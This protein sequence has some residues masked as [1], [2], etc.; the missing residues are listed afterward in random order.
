[1][2]TPRNLPGLA[3][4]AAM[5]AAGTVLLGATDQQ[6]WVRFMTLMKTP[7]PRQ[8]KALMKRYVIERELEGVGRMTGQQLAEAA[9]KSNEAIA[10]LGAPSSGFGTSEFARR[11]VQCSL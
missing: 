8:G 6:R 9:T 4:V 2:T 5:L 10:K 1:M 7:P 3:R 11:R